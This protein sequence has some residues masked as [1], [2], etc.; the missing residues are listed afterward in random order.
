MKTRPAIRS[1]VIRWLCQR[2][3]VGLRRCQQKAMKAMKAAINDHLEPDGDED[4]MK[5]K[6]LCAALMMSWNLWLRNAPLPC[7]A[8]R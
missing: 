1:Q 7:A 6:K 3:G 5:S 2:R 4:D 8:C